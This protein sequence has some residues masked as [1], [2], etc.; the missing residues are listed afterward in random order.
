MSKRKISGGLLAFV[1]ILVLFASAK[2][3][4]ART[5]ICNGTLALTGSIYSYS[6]PQFTMSG[7][8]FVDREKA[9]RDRI[10]ADWLNNGAIWARLGI[11]AAQQNAYCASGGTFRVDYGFD[12]RKKDWNFTQFVRPPCRCNGPLIF[13]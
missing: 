8:L 7:G 6:I 11:P 12:K 5:W 13:Q 9:C 3:T 4:Q 2:P 10:K 1:A